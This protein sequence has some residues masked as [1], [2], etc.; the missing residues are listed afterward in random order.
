MGKLKIKTRDW[1][2]VEGTL[3]IEYSPLYQ[4]E[5]PVMTVKEIAVGKKPEQEVATF[6]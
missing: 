2:V 1:V 4:G 5:G 6:Y 3:A